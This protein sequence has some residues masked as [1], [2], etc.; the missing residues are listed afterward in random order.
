MAHQEQLAPGAG[1]SRRKLIATGATLAVA[2]VA[3]G[4]A[5]TLA[6]S[7]VQGHAATGAAP[8]EPVM[9][10]VQDARSGRLDLFVGERKIS[11]T[12]HALATEL[13]KQAANAT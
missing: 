3:V 12:D 4:T 13:V 6:V 5:G 7:A 9:V 1:L 10:H 2:G 11:F 8:E